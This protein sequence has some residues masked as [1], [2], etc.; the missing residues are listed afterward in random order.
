V[1]FVLKPGVPKSETGLLFSIFTWEDPVTH[2]VYHQ[3][4]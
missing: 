1:H 3:A 4:R 2:Q